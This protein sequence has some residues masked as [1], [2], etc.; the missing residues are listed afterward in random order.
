LK[1]QSPKP[2]LLEVWDWN[3][4]KS[5]CAAAWSLPR[6]YYWKRKER[7]KAPRFQLVLR[8]G[9]IS[10]ALHSVWGYDVEVTVYVWSRQIYLCIRCIDLSSCVSSLSLIVH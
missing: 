6:S 7:K 5:P 3:Q 4:V 9:P 10:P 1:L 8:V 2:R